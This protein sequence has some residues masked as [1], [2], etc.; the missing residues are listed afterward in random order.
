MHLFDTHAHLDD[1]QLSEETANILHDA[2][3]CGVI[4]VTAIGTTVESSQSCLDL[5]MQFESVYAAV[6]IHPNRCHEAQPDAWDHIT[7]MSQH[8]RTVALGETGLDR[9]WDYC[10]F[11]IQVDWFRKHIELSASSGLPLVIHMRDC[12]TDILEVLAPQARIAPINGIMHSFAGGW[13]TARQCLDWG[14]HISFAGMVT[15]KK[16]DELRKIAAQVPME[17][18]LIETDSPYLTP[19]PHRSVRPNTPAMVA[20]TAQCLADVKGI[21]VSEFADITTAN[22]KRIFKI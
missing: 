14:M 12:E 1:P 22:A 7:K 8:E 3:R 13:E 5:A 2:A 6:G 21:P 4:G 15:F 19:H 17:R 11:E 20:H 18:M 9:H 16:S 10:P